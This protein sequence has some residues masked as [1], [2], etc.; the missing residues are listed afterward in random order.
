MFSTKKKKDKCPTKAL[1]KMYFALCWSNQTCQSTVWTKLA[2][3][4]I[5]ITK[6]KKLFRIIQHQIWSNLIF[7]FYVFPNY[8]QWRNWHLLYFVV[9]IIVVSLNVTMFVYVSA[10]YTELI[11]RVIDI[12]TINFVLMSRCLTFR[13]QRHCIL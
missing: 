5:I 4:Q 3:F 10:P 13:V 11:L 7:L 12:L 8:Y 1:S 9:G 6:C 2:P